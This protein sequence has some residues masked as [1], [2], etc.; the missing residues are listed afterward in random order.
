MRLPAS[1]ELVRLHNCLL[2]GVAVLVGMIV[3]VISRDI[4]LPQAALAFIV[5]VIICGGG[6]AINDYCDR[7]I[8]AINRP[9]RPI[10]SGRLEPGQALATGRSLFMIGVLLAI[11]LGTPCII[12]AIVNSLVLAFYSARLKHLGLIGNLT[13]G[14]LV[15]STL[16]FGGLAVKNVP[17]LQAISLQSVSIFAAMAALSTIGRELIKDIEDMKGDKKIGLK[18]FPLRHGTR[19][20]AA[21]AIVFIAAAVALSPLPYLLDLFDVV[22]LAPVIL[23]VLIFIGAAAIV[24]RSQKSKAA[25][26]ASLACKVGMGFGMLAFLA[27]AIL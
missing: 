15:G 9:G 24:A 18:T 10:P 3:A 16:L 27:G 20:A 21:L 12:L 13:I 25:S 6:N 5:A 7:K 23:S 2:A 22:Y 19:A 8:D 4:P 1:L 26:R 11:P 14:Y 17:R